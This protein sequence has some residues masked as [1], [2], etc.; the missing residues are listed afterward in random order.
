MNWMRHFLWIITVVHRAIYRVSGG[1]LGGR[2]MGF[3][4]LML[5][6]VGRKTGLPRKTPILFVE[7][8][9]R[10]VVAASNA[11][12]DFDPAWWLNLQATPEAR[13]RVGR[14]TI[15]VKARRATQEEETRLW[16]ILTASWKWFD[17]YR[18]ATGRDIPVV[19]LEPTA[20]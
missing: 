13:V 2:S 16:P 17:K 14:R 19:I 11:G 10:F 3:R 4:F 8:E 15:E 1:W 5:E 6:H 18:S 7:D 20:G 12:Q 9:G